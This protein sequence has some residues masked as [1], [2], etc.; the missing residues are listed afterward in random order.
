[1]ILMT[2][3]E[4]GVFYWMY[5]MVQKNDKKERDALKITRLEMPVIGLCILLNI[6]LTSLLFSGRGQSIHGLFYSVFLAMLLFNAM[7]DA[8]IKKIYRFYSVL[9]CIISFVYFGYQAI[10]GYGYSD[11]YI[12]GLA[13]GTGIYSVLLYAGHKIRLFHSGEA[14][15]N[16]GDAIL[17]VG[18]CAFLSTM[19]GNTP[20]LRLETFG[21]HFVLT[22]LLMIIGNVVGGIDWKRMRLKTAAAYCPYMYAATL[23][24]MAIMIWAPGLFLAFGV[25]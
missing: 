17:M 14:I 16:T 22:N 1:M 24:M 23:L 10:S 21:I 8:K 15:I 3:I 7:V 9:L 18:S 11:A 19:T 20:M 5:Q 4:V 25:E 2:V 12:G 13:V 6:L